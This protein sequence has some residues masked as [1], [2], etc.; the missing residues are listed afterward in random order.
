MKKRRDQWKCGALYALAIVANDGNDSIVAE[1][2]G[3][4]GIRSEE[5]LESSG[6]EDCDI[7]P[8]RRFFR[9][10]NNGG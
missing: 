4:M 6:A 5:D 3:C 7:D 9:R 1:V 8:L 2:L 10:E